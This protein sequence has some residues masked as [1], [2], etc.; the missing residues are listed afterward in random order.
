MLEVYTQ[1]TSAPT[2]DPSC[3]AGSSPLQLPPVSIIEEIQEPLVMGTII[4]PDVYLGQMIN[5]FMVRVSE[6]HISISQMRWPF[7]CQQSAL[8]DLATWAVTLSDNVNSL[9]CSQFEFDSPCV[10]GSG[11]PFILAIF[12]AGPWHA[13]D[14][15]SC[16]VYGLLFNVGIRIRLGVNEQSDC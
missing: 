9:T 12:Q 7:R 16:S 14:R 6:C 8:F 3:H 4:A 13:L 1:Q 2:V 5:L 15:E 10:L 11:L